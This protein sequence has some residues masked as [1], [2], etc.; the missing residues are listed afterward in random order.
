MP[1]PER[2]YELK[3]LQHGIVFAVGLL[4][5]I[6]AMGFETSALVDSSVT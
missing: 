4:T 5:N 2:S 6:Q 1:T 3:A